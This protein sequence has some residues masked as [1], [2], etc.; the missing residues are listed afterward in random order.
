MGKADPLSDL[1]D[2]QGSARHRFVISHLA[3]ARPGAGRSLADIAHHLSQIHGHAPGLLDLLAERGLHPEIKDWINQTR[4]AMAQERAYMTRL[5][6]AVGPIPGTPRAT[7]GEALLLARRHAI[8]TLARS[9]RIGCTLGAAVGLMLDWPVLR[10]LLDVAARRF[11][12]EP[13]PCPMPGSEA[14]K[15]VIAEAD[16]T[17][18]MSRA[19]EF[20]ARQLLLQHHALWDLLQAREASR[21]DI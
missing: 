17:G 12:I 18:T 7:E 10:D 3:P 8:D 1:V 19:I 4:T 11:G 6:I 5:L 13:A 9:D 14:A 15:A 21:P 16:P 20:G 2:A